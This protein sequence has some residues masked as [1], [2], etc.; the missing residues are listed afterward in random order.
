LQPLKTYIKI[1]KTPLPTL[2]DTETLVY[3]ISEDLARKLKLKIEVN[4]ET[5]VTLLGR[6]ARLRL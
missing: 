4:D 3:I 1:A 6:K 2:I 5:K